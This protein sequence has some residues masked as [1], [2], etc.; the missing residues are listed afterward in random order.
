MKSISERIIS[1]RINQTNMS[2]ITVLQELIN[3][4]ADTRLETHLSELWYALRAPYGNIVPISA[5]STL[6]CVWAENDLTSGCKGYFGEL[7]GKSDG[8]VYKIIA[9]NYKAMYRE[10]ETVLF[11]EE[12]EKAKLKTL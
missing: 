8:L 6:H 5:L 10:R 9:E 4:R 11:M 3:K 7:F 2:D 1:K 12:V